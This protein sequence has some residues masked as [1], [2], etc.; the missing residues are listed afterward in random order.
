MFREVVIKR[1]KKDIERQSSEIDLENKKIMDEYEGVIEE[2]IEEFTKSFLEDAYFEKKMKISSAN[3]KVK[4]E[5]LKSKKNMIDVIFAQVVSLVKSF[6]GTS[7]YEVYLR[8]ITRKAI[9]EL[10]LSS[11][12]I[13]EIGKNNTIEKEIILD[14]LLINGYSKEKITFNI[15]DYDLIGGAIFLNDSKMFRID[16]CL[17]SLIEHNRVYIGQLVFEMLNEAGEYNE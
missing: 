6:V 5:I 8:D 17:D 10:N 11:G 9:S 15:L 4:S 1:V 13:I 2:K 3:S 14:E 16:F 12:I 7:S